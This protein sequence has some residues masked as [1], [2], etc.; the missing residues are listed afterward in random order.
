MPLS[1]VALGKVKARCTHLQ[2][3]YRP[4]PALLYPFNAA[5]QLGDLSNQRI[6]A[7]SSKNATYITGKGGFEYQ[8]YNM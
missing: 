6:Q 8:T 7:T 5:Y 3:G 4:T 2:S 1:L